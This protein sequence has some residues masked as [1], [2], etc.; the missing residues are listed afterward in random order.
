MVLIIQGLFNWFAKCV[1]LEKVQG[2]SLTKVKLLYTG[3]ILLI[4]VQQSQWNVTP[5]SQH[6]TLILT[7]IDLHTFISGMVLISSSKQIPQ[8]SFIPSRLWSLTPYSSPVGLLWSA[9]RCFWRVGR[10]F[11]H[12]C[13]TPPQIHLPSSQAPPG[14]ICCFHSDTAKMAGK[15]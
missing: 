15:I 6:T 2:F 11:G 10:T 12:W 9:A 13:R 14:Y 1:K 4:P 8:L 5:N 3:I 7:L